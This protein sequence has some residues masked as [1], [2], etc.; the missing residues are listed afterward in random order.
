MA[1]VI[2]G[3]AAFITQYALELFAGFAILLLLS[4]LILLVI[5]IRRK[6]EDITARLHDISIDL[7]S[8]QERLENVIKDEITLN[9]Q[10]TA[11]SARQKFDLR[12]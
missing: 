1:Q 3:V 7:D 8:K 4:V 5:L 12:E 10:E 9:R 6:P 2:N 11:N